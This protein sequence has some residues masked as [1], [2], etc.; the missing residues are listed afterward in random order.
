MACFYFFYLK[1]YL[2]TQFQGSNDNKYVYLWKINISQIESL[3]ELSIHH[4]QTYHFHYIRFQTCL[5]K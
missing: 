3:D 4:N 1:I 5:K 2:L